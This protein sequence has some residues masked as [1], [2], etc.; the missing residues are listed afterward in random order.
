MIRIGFFVVSTTLLIAS[1]F[2]G[3]SIAKP[4]T[5]ANPGVTKCRIERGGCNTDCDIYTGTLKK[6]CKAR[7]TGRWNSCINKL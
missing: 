1:G 2:A 5:S 6:G 3:D 4:A 7:C